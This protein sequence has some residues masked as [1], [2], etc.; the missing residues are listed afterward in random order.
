MTLSHLLRFL[1]AALLLL[2]PLRTDAA[3]VRLLVAI[4]AN[5]GDPDDAVLS[6][7]DDDA[8][9]VRQLFVELGEVRADRAYLVVNSPAA[10]VRQ[11][12]A[13][14]AGRIAEL[15]A[16]GD[17]AVLILYASA[18]AKGGV[19]HLA[20]SHLA[21]SEL[22]DSARQAG[23]RLSVLLVDACESGTLARRKGGSAG[24]EF[25]VSL[26]QLPLHGQ[27]IISSSG[28]GE[29]SEEWDSLKGSLFTHHLLTG[30]RGDA[31]AEGDGRVSLSEAYAYAYRRTVAGAAGPGQHPAYA[32]ELSGTGELILT[33]PK[34]A[35]SA[36]IF[37]AQLSGRYVVASQP[38]PDV[39]AEV[40]KAPGR[41]LRLAVPPGRYLLRKRAGQSTGLLE[42]ELPYGGERQVREEELTWRRY[43]EVALKG[44][45]MELRNSALLGLARLESAPVRDTGT[46][47]SAGLGYRHSWGPWW[48]LGTV[49]F[50][51]ARYPAVELQ[52]RERALGAGVAGGYRWLS[53]AL[54]PHVGLGL[55]LTGV[56]QRLRR[57]REE[58]IQDTV[59]EPL[60]TRRALGVGVGPLLGVE[61]PLPGQ[62]FALLQGQVLLRYLP[63][64][65][66]SALRPAALLSAGAGWRF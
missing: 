32:W 48:A 25:A 26:E 60:P 21:L 54:V 40:D 41:P 14:V 45:Y 43:T 30:L 42:V 37:P 44:G 57:D 20:G 46:R 36:L 9:R 10:V 38:R 34:V 5:V 7:A 3:T 12:L 17:D 1:P 22:R 19:L 15:R 24:P 29:S 53:W 8:E 61:V 52:V 33:E 62:A 49:S 27:V 55:E 58:E 23:A 64:Q 39:V 63:S 4:G 18:H 66:Q 28:P 2:S 13:E 11:K 31:D 51:Q 65:E 59:G 6:F 47:L 56:E 35:R 50:T 16:A